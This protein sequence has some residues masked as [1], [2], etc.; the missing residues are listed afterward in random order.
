VRR[1][2]ELN[3]VGTSGRQ[4]VPKDVF[5]NL[6]LELPE[7]TTT[8]A[9]I[10]S[11]LS[12][13]DDKMELNRKMNDTLEQ[14]AQTFFKKYFVNDIDEDNLP[15]GWKCG[16]IG[17]LALNVRNNINQ[18]EMKRE[19][20]YVGLEHV[21][22]RSIALYDFGSSE[23]LE[24]N[25][26]KFKEDDILFG[27]LRP[28]FHK[29]VFAPFE[30][31]CSTDILVIEPREKSYFSFCLCHFSSEEIIEYATQFSDGTRMPRI[32]WESLSKYEIIIPP[33]KRAKE[34]ND[35]VS[36]LVKKIKE[37]INEMRLL[38]QIRDSLL[39]KL[40]SGEIDV[41]QLLNHE[42]GV[43]MSDT[44]EAELII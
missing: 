33:L 10:A 3:M 12:A 31:I 40:M 13:V 6:E 1:F 20:K 44:T 29:V 9:R 36:P 11:I 30:G 7:D 21:P 15:E 27:K 14:I 19:M 23:K 35:L 22:R 17:E 32:N 37:V 16:T 41:S 4:R 8:Q 2:A 5:E 38:S 26:F 18:N 28:Y 25:K 39:P 43:E 24:S 34:F 42:Q